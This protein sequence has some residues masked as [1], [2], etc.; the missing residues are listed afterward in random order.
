MA[1]VGMNAAR[2]REKHKELQSKTYTT[3]G[4]GGSGDYPFKM[5]R[6]RSL[7]PGRYRLRLLWTDPIKNPEG[8]LYFATHKV[9][10]GSKETKNEVKHEWLAASC[11][12]ANEAYTGVTQVLDLIEQYKMV[13]QLKAAGA[14][15]ARHC[16]VIK[17]LNPW[18]RYWI[19][20]F[21][22]AVEV[23]PSGDSQYSSFVP[24]TSADAKP[25]DKILE[26]NFNIKMMDSL[27][28]AF[29]RY[30]DCCDA[31]VGRDFVLEVMRNHHYK[32]E[33]A[34][35]P[36]PLDLTL[37]QHA[38]ENYPDLPKLCKKWNY[39]DPEEIYSLLASQWWFPHFVNGVDDKPKGMNLVFPKPEIGGL[40]V[41]GAPA[42]GTG[43]LPQ[44]A[45][46]AA[47][48][49]AVVPAPVIPAAQP[50]VAPTVAAAPAAVAPVVAP[51]VA[52][53][54]AAPSGVSIAW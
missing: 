23:P 47:A 20:A 51:V 52:P 53:P 21:I 27:F 40:P 7:N 48:A 24:T 49:V 33:A 30:P 41:I 17:N 25:L 46:A 26:V 3:M 5:L 31:T 4:Q 2:L 12:P 15:C 1:M 8:V 16:E 22:W 34:I 18:Q 43:L 36:S 39:K 11:L 32:L 6:I 29:E 13:D 42:A 9:I 54:A 37:F 44:T 50:V 35:N 19:P 45:P 14:Q 38:Q 28:E 10:E